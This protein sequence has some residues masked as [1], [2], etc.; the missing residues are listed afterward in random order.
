LVSVRSYEYNEQNDVSIQKRYF[1]QR[2]V[3]YEEHFERRYDASGNEIETKQLDKEGELDWVYKYTYDKRG[4][5]LKSVSFF[6]GRIR[7]E[8]NKKYKKGNCVENKLFDYENEAQRKSPNTFYFHQYNKQGM[9]VK[10]TVHSVADYLEQKE[11]AI[12]TYQ[13]N[14]AGDLIEEERTRNGTLSS[15]TTIQ[16]TYW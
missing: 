5:R 1:V 9:K 15:I 4:N 16:N 6:K 8:W 12:Y 3:H 2:D 7:E 13:Y 10:T 11:I 14:D